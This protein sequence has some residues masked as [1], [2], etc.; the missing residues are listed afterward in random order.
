MDQITDTHESLEGAMVALIGVV[1][2]EEPEFSGMASVDEL[3]V[4]TQPG[5]L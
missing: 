4:R 1:I 5:R 3:S 2:E